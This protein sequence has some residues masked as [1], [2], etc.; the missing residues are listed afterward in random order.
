[1]TATHSTGPASAAGSNEQRFLTDDTW[2][3]GGWLVFAGTVL[4]LAGLMRFVDAIWAFRYSG[5]LPEDLKDGLL[6]SY[7]TAYAWAWLIVGVILVIAS[8]LLLVRSQIARWIGIA[9]AVVQGL[10]AMTWMPYYPV[11]SLVYVGMAVLVL[12]ALLAHGGRQAT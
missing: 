11:W 9:A 2:R 3:P 6:G 10:S 8:F 12:Y 4:G 7:L 1:M 5:A